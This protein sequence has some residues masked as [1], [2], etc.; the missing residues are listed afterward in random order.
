V[1]F[2]S[3]SAGLRDYAREL[4][5]DYAA[6][7]L[8]APYASSGPTGASNMSTTV[9][10]QKSIEN[11]VASMSLTEAYDILNEVKALAHT[12]NRKAKE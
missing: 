6:P 11:T 8:A 10:I 5:Q 2:T 1:S 3:N 4:G 9:N 7:F 12:D